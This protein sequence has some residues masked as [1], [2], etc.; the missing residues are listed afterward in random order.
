ML[1]QNIAWTEL[2]C[3]HEDE[4]SKLSFLGDISDKQYNIF[5]SSFPRESWE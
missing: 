5:R 2:T 3:V 1:E 4:T